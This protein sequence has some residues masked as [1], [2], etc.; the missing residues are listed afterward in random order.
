MIAAISKEPDSF[1]K[2]KEI[3]AVDFVVF[4]LNLSV[5]LQP[6]I[7]IDALFCLN[8]MMNI[9]PIALDS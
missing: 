7:N 5:T 3:S 1:K 8:N 6:C 9:K 2:I 4:A